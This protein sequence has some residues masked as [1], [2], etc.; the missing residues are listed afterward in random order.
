MFLT[1]AKNTFAKFYCHTEKNLKKQLKKR[2]KNELEKKI[3]SN[4]NLKN[5]KYT[6]SK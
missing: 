1:F 6:N 4:Q 2:C 5:I 3:V